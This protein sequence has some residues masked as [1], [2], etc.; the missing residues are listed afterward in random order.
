M[1]PDRPVTIGL[2]TAFNPPEG[3]IPNCEALL[4]ECSG[5]VVVDDGS[6]LS[7]DSIF[8]ALQALGCSV[9]RL[10]SNKGIASALNA[11][12]KQAQSLYQRL[13]FIL[14]MDQD[15]LIQPGFVRALEEAAE[16]AQS[17]GVKVGMVAPANVS[18]LPKRARTLP[19]GVTL[20]DEPVQSGLLIPTGCLSAVGPFN[21][22][23]FIDGVDSEFYLR[24]KAVG[25]VCIIA[26]GASLKH[27][28]G[29]MVPASIGPMTIRW[30]GQ[31]VMVR[32]AASWRYYYIVR[33]RIFLFRLYLPTQ[34]YWAVRGALMD[35]RH[36]VLVTALANGRRVRLAA[37]LRGVRDGVRGRMGPSPLS[38]SQ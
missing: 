9:V 29:Q 24:A 7:A 3:L 25:M 37:A 21:E 12:V 4:R 28:L 22:R 11:G 35:L 34:P 13:D 32:T 30:R 20:G 1:A 23:L 18:G 33:N 15:S 8:D 6:D 5:V 16:N 27:S 2:V 19:N 31:P 26:M 14:T 38:K 10:R 17:T 36:L